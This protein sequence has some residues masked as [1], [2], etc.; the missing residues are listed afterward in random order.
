[1]TRRSRGAISLLEIM[2][3]GSLGLLVLGYVTYLLVQ[4]TRSSLRAQAQVGL[5]QLA[6]TTMNRLVRDLQSSTP[7]GITWEPDLGPTHLRV[8]A[9]QPLLDVDGDGLPIYADTHLLTYAFDPALRSL[10]RREW[11]PPQTMPVPLSNTNPSRLT[12]SQLLGCLSTNQFSLETSVPNLNSF[13][14]SNPYPPPNL[15][16]PFELDLGFRQHVVSGTQDEAFSVQR[17]V[18]LRNPK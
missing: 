2:I 12:N 16:N 13:Q 14:F 1:M 15:G 6:L 8:L 10:R 9:I 11:L 17:V 7:A 5:Q 4:T 18:V 3:A